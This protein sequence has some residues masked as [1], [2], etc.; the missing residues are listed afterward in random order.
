MLQWCLLR[1]HKE[2]DDKVEE[3]VT[4]LKEQFAKGKRE[5][6]GVD[7]NNQNINQDETMTQNNHNTGE[8]TAAKA[9]T[10]IRVSVTQGPHKGKR[11]DLRPQQPNDPCMVGRSA[12]KKYRERGVSLKKDTEVSTTHGR[13]EIIN[14]VAYFTDMAST[15]GTT[16]QDQLLE[17]NQPFRL[18]DGTELVLGG[19]HLEIELLT[20]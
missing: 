11:F 8:K 10:V 13:F 19:S 5:L 3:I 1:N 12:G 7:G 14:G 16:H 9:V 6:L 2:T 18:Q 20:S 17:P 4:S 15:N